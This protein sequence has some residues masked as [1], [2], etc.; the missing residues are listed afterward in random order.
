MKKC[1]QY[2]KPYWTSSLSTLSDN[3]RA[4]RKSYIK[5]NTDT[6][7]Q[8]L[9]DAREAFN[10]ERKTACQDFLINKAKQLNS[11]QAQQF[12]K[13]FNKIFKKKTTQ[14]IDP[15]DDGNKG[16]ITDTKDVEA[17]LFSVFFEAKHLLNGNFDD[18]FYQEVNNLY[19]GIIEEDLDEQ[20]DDI[21]ENV[22]NLN[23]NITVEEIMKAIKCTGK[24]V[25]NFKF[26]P[27]MF[28]HLGE[29]AKNI[30]SRL[31][32]LCLSTKTWVWEA[33]EVIFLR[34]AGKDSYA[35]PGSYRPICITAYIGK[36]MESIVARRIEQLL[37]DSNQTDPD[38][39]GF[40]QLKNTIRYLNRLNL[41]IKVDKENYLTVLCLFIDFEK[42]FDSVWKKGLIVKLHHIGIKGNV[43]KLI[44]NFLCT[45]KVALNINGEI[46]NSR[47][48]AE[49]GLPQG[50]VLSPVLFKIYLMDFVSELNNHPNIVIYKFADDGTIK[51]S[52]R[53][54]QISLDILDRVLLTLQ[55][56]CRKWRMKLNCD[57][58]KT[59]IIAFN[60]AERNKDLIPEQFSLGDKIIY[61][62]PQT[63]VL[64]L[65]IDEHLTYIPHSKEVLKGLHA[66]WA[67]LCK[68]SSRHW[69]FNQKI[70][71]LLVKTLFISKLSY[72][73]H[74]W[75]SKENTKD[76]LSLWYQILKSIIGSVLNISHNIAEVIVGV[77]P[78]LIQATVN[79]IKHF[80]KL[81]IKPVQND[82]YTKFIANSYNDQN[83]STAAI[84]NTLKVIFKFLQWK[85]KEYENQFTVEDKVIISNNLYGQF[86]SLS[87]KACSYTQHMMQLYTES[88]LWSASLKTQFQLDGYQKYPKPSCTALPIP[89]NTNRSSEVLLMSVMYK[90]NL[91]NSSLYKLGK[92]PSPLCDR[93]KEEEETV[94]H[95]IFRCR[96]VDE[97]LR[98]QALT[99]YREANNLVGTE[100]IVT[101]YIDLLS[102][103][104][105]ERFLHACLNIVECNNMRHTITL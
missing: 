53:N 42:A 96:E 34:K 80:L 32:N 79:G 72:A 55:D 99:C 21:D 91:M 57:R 19:E 31:F 58:N 69:G 13:E 50:S 84:H 45:R 38:Q 20:H 86:F 77:P 85:S 65:T 41:G 36:L 101:D 29:R 75:M 16:V 33:A 48:G 63:K 10:N 70:M 93:C 61:R 44:N 98:A 68:Y 59:E 23:R 43:L 18:V 74:I 89:A 6:N 54:S 17:C 81:N 15:L 92:V 14:K 25:D 5:R 52:A 35:K 46:G 4:A 1:S 39:E 37:L 95:T 60:T 11:A 90:N 27:T 49:Y 97:E 82:R 62:V 56:W 76:I 64:G 71:V 67:T 87:P 66:V 103:S 28:R 30:L 102:S 104:R 88:Q 9:N 2:S 7:L 40:S 100:D 47:Q 3:L 12:W 73:S 78:I 105:H 51:I 94:D 24:S 83:V 8:K 26:H 22:Y